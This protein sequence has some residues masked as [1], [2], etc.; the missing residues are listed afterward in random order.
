MDL[1]ELRRG[2]VHGWAVSRDAQSPVPIA[3]G[4][5]I[6]PGKPENL[7]RYVLDEHDEA[8]LARLDGEPAG[9]EIKVFGG[10]PELRAALRPAWAMYDPC[11]LMS[12]PFT[13]RAAQV[14]APYAAELVRCGQVLTALARD[15]GGAVVCSARLAM[16]GEFG[17]ADQVETH[18]DHR[19]RGLGAAL[20]TLLGNWAAG[21]GLTTGLLAATAE[22]RA[23]YSSLGW[24]DHGEIAGAFRAR[25]VTAG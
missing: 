20:M 25:E 16:A 2:W 23:L 10:T 6:E 13:E 3:G 18:P 8:I 7:V 19:R 14:P 5:R 9:T 11:Y 12:V 4:Y 17:I 15:P 22:G 24:A 1:A 21:D